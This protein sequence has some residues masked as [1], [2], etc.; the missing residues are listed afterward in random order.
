M[1]EDDPF[2]VDVDRFRGPLDLLLHLV[3]SQDIDVFDIPI[4]RITGQFLASV[5]ALRERR[6]DEAGEFLEM[7]A[8]LVRIKSA[9]LLPD[10]AADDAE[11]PRAELVRRLL[12]YEVVREIATR[13]RAAENDRSRRFAKGWVEP[14]RSERGEVVELRATWDQLFRAALQVS[15]AGGDPVHRVV[16]RPVAMRDKVDLILGAVGRL[17]RV[18][19]ASL[20]APWKDRMH[21]VMTFLA[22][23]ELGRR[24]EVSLRQRAHFSPLWIRARSPDAGGAGAAEGRDA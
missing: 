23:L 5:A 15:A 8:T 2:V 20:V 9:T 3:R 24:R 18:D 7:A 12:E 16:A 10:A 6:V 4:G 21:A 22:G 19:F 14:R 13:L 1:M 11:D 17:E